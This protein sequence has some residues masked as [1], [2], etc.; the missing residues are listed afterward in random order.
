[1][2]IKYDTPIE[3]TREQYYRVIKK[4]AEIVAYRIDK[5]GKYWVKLW[6]MS[7]KEKL[8]KELEA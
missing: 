1:M 6:V 2:E 7:F 4:F 5:Q 3:V 8:R